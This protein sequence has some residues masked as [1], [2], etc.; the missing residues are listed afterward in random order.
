MDIALMVEGQDGLNWER[1]QRIARTAEDV[2]FAG[3]YRSD[4]FTN[5]VGPFKDSLECWTSLTWLAS[6]SSRLE[7]GPLVSPVSFRHPAMLVRQA[8]AVADLSGGRLQFGLGAGW[9]DREHTNYG[10]H[11]GSVAERMARFR[12]SVHIMAHLLRSE[13]PLDFDGKY[14][15]MHEAVLLPRPKQHVPIVIGGSGRQ[16]TLPLVAR[17]ADEWNSGG[18][19]PEQFQEINAYLD[20]LLDRAERPRSSVRR[21]MMIFLRF[22]RDR[23]DLEARLGARPVPESMQ[24]GTLAATP[25]QLR[26]RLTALEGVGVQRVILNWMDDYDDVDGMAALGQSV[27]GA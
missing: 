20:G 25:E 23:A 14:Y 11:L 2:G 24:R 6:H 21:S 7:F 22:G 3:L 27:I 8:A 18:R 15:S 5:P 17:Y 13:Q 19:S 10:Y 1:W 26:E 4:H 12:E 16:V 9:Q